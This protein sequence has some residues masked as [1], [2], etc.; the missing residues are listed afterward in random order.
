MTIRGQKTNYIKYNIGDIVKERE[1]IFVSDEPLYGMIIQIERK[2]FNQTQ[3]IPYEDDRI[4]VF[5]F[6]WKSTE[7]LP[8]TFVELVSK[9]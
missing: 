1:W 3:W 5:W 6:K 2:A 9:A 7:I 4:C 8:A